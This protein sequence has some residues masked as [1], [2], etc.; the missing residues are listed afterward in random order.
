M[1]FLLRIGVGFLI[2]AAGV[3]I[4]A[5]GVQE[6]GTVFLLSVVCTAGISLPFWVAL[7]FVA[8]WAALAV[9]NLFHGP[10][11]DRSE[12]KPERALTPAMRA[13]ALANYIAKAHNMG[14]DR[15]IVLDRLERMGWR[16]AEIEAAW[17][18]CLSAAATSTM[19][20]SP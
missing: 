17:Q 2:T 19:K 18:K 16:A 8:G 4:I 7:W 20:D 14:M 11:H 12:S 5:G 1:T 13:R 3:C 6:G 15:L 9:V 10:I